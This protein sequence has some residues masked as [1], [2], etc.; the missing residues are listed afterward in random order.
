MSSKWDVYHQYYAK[1]GL[2]SNMHY[3]EREEVVLGIID[4]GGY[5]GQ[6]G[7]IR[8]YCPFCPGKVG[9][10]DR[11]QSFGVNTANGFY[12]CHRC[13]T[14]GKVDVGDSEIQAPI[15]PPVVMPDISE[16]ELPETYTPLWLEPGLNAAVLSDA[17]A[18]LRSRGLGRAAWQKANIGACYDGYHAN[19][20][21]VPI[22]DEAQE[23]WIGWVA[24]DW[25]GTAE[26]KYM[27]P[28][29]MHRSQIVFQ[30][31]VLQEESDAPVLVVEGVFDALP[32]IGNAVAL[33]GKPSGLQFEILKKSKRPLAVVL[34]GD[35]WEEGYT[36]SQRLQ[37]EGKRAG[38]VKLPPG[39]DPGDSD[40][41]WLITEAALCVQ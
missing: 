35:A 2:G 8:A 19:R 4:E 7:W 28:L 14:K 34:D 15:L 16:I 3:L 32:Y 33:L 39:S 20:V 30:Q 17:R 6:T 41:N 1:A 24:R 26:R 36:L 11:R 29:G 31:H 13:G 38:Y 5:V 25:T 22:L 9:T 40:Q 27:Y 12:V 10:Q 18:Y 37:L 23:K 21:V